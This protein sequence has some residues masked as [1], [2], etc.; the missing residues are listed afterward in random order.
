MKL[1]DLVKI[2]DE[3]V[4]FELYIQD[5]Y[6]RIGTFSKN[7]LGICKYEEEEVVNIYCDC[8]KMIIKLKNY[9]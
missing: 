3:E 8:G 1:K 6:D 2:L 9:V 4:T 7:D 5:I